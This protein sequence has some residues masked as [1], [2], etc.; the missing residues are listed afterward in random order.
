MLVAIQN[1]KKNNR[2]YKKFDEFAIGAVI[3]CDNKIIAQSGNRYKIDGFP[4]GHA[5]MVAIQK[6]CNKS[7]TSHLHKCVLYTTNEPCPMCATAAVIAELDGIVYGANKKD[8]R[9]YW[10]V[11]EGETSKQYKQTNISCEEVLKRS[12]PTLFVVKDFMRK[13]CKELFNLYK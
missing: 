6:A 1:A 2:V 3:V 13:E 10:T 9:R 7:G 4:Q 11:E 5:E 12:N 8:M